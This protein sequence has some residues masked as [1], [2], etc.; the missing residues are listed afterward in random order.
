MG[1]FENGTANRAILLHPSCTLLCFPCSNLTVVQGIKDLLYMKKVTNFPHILCFN[2]PI[3][4]LIFIISPLISRNT[5]YVHS[6]H[7]THQNIAKKFQ[8]IF[9]K[10]GKSTF[11][12]ENPFCTK[13]NLFLKKN[14]KQ[15]CDV[16]FLLFFKWFHA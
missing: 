4:Y 10:R 9:I 7:F 11:G 13:A 16:K 8:V 14:R 6:I 12:P 2:M 1:I 5:I 15:D 3:Y